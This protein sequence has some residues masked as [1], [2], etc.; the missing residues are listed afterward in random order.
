[1]QR[2][3]VHIVGGSSGRATIP[4]DVGALRE[5][6]RVS[7]EVADAGLAAL[8]EAASAAYDRGQAELAVN[9]QLQGLFPRG[10]LD[11]RRD[12]YELVT[13]FLG[14]DLADLDPWTQE[15]RASLR[16]KGYGEEQIA[17]YTKSIYHFRVFFD[18]MRF[19]YSK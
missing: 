1:M 13:R 12:Y 2:D 19:L 7:A 6:Y 11:G 18:R 3:E 4:G 14:A 17:T 15:A 9:R 5:I 16:A 8:K 10:F